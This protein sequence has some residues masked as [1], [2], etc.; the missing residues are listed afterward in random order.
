MPKADKALH[1]GHS[2][3]GSAFHKHRDFRAWHFGSLQ[4]LVILSDSVE[5]G[6]VHP[7]VVA[8]RL[9]FYTCRVRAP[10]VHKLLQWCKGIKSRGR[11][12]RGVIDVG[13]FLEVTYVE[14]G[15]KRAVYTG[16]RKRDVRSQR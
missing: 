8:Y 14:E 1:F 15:E 3:P 5:I 12:R 4:H 10:I 11:E 2:S 6:K 16:D 13:T 7:G 9:D